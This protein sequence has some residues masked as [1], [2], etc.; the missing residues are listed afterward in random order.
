[1]SKTYIIIA[2]KFNGKANT[3]N[4]SKKDLAKTKA[5]EWNKK[6]CKKLTVFTDKYEFVDVLV[7]K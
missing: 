1:M 6:D 5:S 4:V 3:L 2:L 7:R